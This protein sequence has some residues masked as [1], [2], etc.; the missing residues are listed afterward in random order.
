M[1]Y[2]MTLQNVGGPGKVEI[3]STM[4]IVHGCSEMKSSGGENF[5]RNEQTESHRTLLSSRAVYWQKG[6][7]SLGFQLL[8]LLNGFIFTSACLKQ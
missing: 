3:I 8:G 4:I 6:N 7:Q 2:H 5:W 1:P